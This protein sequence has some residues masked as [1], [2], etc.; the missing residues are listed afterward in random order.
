MTKTLSAYWNFLW[1]GLL[2]S[3]QTGAVVPSQRFLIGRMIAPVPESYQGEIIE[4]G[5]GT[6]ALTRRLAQR[7]PQARIL[8]CEINPDLARDC[9]DSLEVSGLN[10]RVEVVCDSAEHL[11]SERVRKG[12]RRPD[13]VISGI[14][15]GTLDRRRVVALVDCVHRSL[16]KGGQYIQF[17][18]SLLDRKN[19]QSRFPKLRVRTAFINFPPAFV[20]YAQK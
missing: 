17:Q 12:K 15:L 5:P 19:I 8:A 1:A 9:S 10:D 20:Y 7:C 11:L 6:G 16:A 4:L 2:K 3:E 18:Y 13:F 14:P